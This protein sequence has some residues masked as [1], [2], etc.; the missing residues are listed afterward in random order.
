MLAGLIR[1]RVAFINEIRHVEAYNLRALVDLDTAKPKTEE[2]KYE[3]LF[4][5]FCFFVEFENRREKRMFNCENL[6]ESTIGL[7]LIVTDQ[8]LSEGQI[9]CF[10]NLF[11]LYQSFSDDHMQLGHFNMFFTGFFDFVNIQNK[12]SA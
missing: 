1:Q 8:Y 4:R 11:Y 6:V 3:D 10:R 2:L 9:Q 5:K 7:R 12:I